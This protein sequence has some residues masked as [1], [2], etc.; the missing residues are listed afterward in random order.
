VRGKYFS[1]S[2]EDWVKSYQQQLF[3][4]TIPEA[5]VANDDDRTFIIVRGMRKGGDGLGPNA[6]AQSACD[7]DIPALED[8]PAAD[9]P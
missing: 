8:K 4:R 5:I 2:S 7:P 1:P 3:E 9:Q 6:L